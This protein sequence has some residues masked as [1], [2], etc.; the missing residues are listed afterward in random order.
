MIRCLNEQSA[1]GT[2]AGLSPDQ[3][4][5]LGKASKNASIALTKDLSD[6]FDLVRGVVKAEPEVLDEEVLYY[7]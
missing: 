2:S 3:L 6:S 5:R 4:N 1:I 7:D